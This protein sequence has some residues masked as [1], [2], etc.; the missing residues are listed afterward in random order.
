MDYLAE[1]TDVVVD[2]ANYYSSLLFSYYYLTT[3]DVVVDMEETKN[4]KEGRAKKNLALFYVR[5]RKIFSKCCK[6]ESFRLEYYSNMKRRRQKWQI[7]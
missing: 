1:T 7:N 2:V 3:A 4:P 6:I 5:K